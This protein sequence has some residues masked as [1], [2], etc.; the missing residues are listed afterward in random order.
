MPGY[1]HVVM[2]NYQPT[3]YLDDDGQPQTH[4]GLHQAVMDVPV[5]DWDTYVDESKWL[6]VEVSDVCPDDCVAQLATP[7]EVD[8][9]AKVAAAIA[10]RPPDPVHSVGGVPVDHTQDTP[11]DSEASA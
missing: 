11:S 4:L 6:K 10:A 3:V 5:D 2:T 9:A 1:K 7:D 8:S